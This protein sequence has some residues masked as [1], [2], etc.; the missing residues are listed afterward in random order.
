MFNRTRIYLD[1]LSGMTTLC[2]YELYWRSTKFG[3]CRTT[4]IVLFENLNWNYSNFIV[5]N[6][7]NNIAP[8]KKLIL[9][10]EGVFNGFLT[11]IYIYSGV[12]TEGED[13]TV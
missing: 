10:K 12:L 11:K 3:S 2:R 9:K 4:F 1:I 13:K 6:I 5:F 7:N 8:K